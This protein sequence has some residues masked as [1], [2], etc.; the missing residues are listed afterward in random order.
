MEKSVQQSTCSTHTLIVSGR[1]IVLNFD[2]TKCDSLKFTQYYLFF[3][4]YYYQCCYCVEKARLQRVHER[5]LLTLILIFARSHWK[6]I[7]RYRRPF[8]K[9][10]PIGGYLL[11]ISF[12]NHRNPYWEYILLS[13]SR[14]RLH[15]MIYQ[16][17]TDWLTSIKT[18]PA[19]EV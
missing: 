18:R 2:S 12:E 17:I 7:S 5:P 19:V 10:S 1:E 14:N 13:G 3:S 9:G 11:L 15:I 4:T 16:T 8:V 6:I